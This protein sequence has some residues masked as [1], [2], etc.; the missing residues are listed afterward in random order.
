MHL[1]EYDD[2]IGGMMCAVRGKK[3]NILPAHNDVTQF[4]N[5][6]I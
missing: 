1:Q 3:F 6:L 2:D 4:Y 5:S